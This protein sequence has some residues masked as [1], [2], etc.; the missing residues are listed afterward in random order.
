MPWNA[1]QAQCRSKGGDL[2]KIQSEE[3]QGCRRGRQSSNNRLSVMAVTR[4]DIEELIEEQLNS[5]EE[6]VTE[7]HNNQTTNFPLS[8]TWLLQAWGYNGGADKEDGEAETGGG[9]GPVDNTRVEA[10]RSGAASSKVEAAVLRA[11]GDGAAIP[12]A[13]GGGAAT[14]R[15]TN[16]ASES[17]IAEGGS[18]SRHRGH[19]A[20]MPRP[21]CA[22]PCSQLA[23]LPGTVSCLVPTPP[24]LE[25]QTSLRKR[26]M[27]L[28]FPLLIA[29]LPL[30][31]ATLHLGF[32]RSLRR[33]TG[34]CLCLSVLAPG[35]RSALWLPW[36]SRL[37]PSL[38]TPEGPT[39]PQ[40]RPWKRAK[41]DI[42]G[43]EGRTSRATILEGLD[44]EQTYKDPSKKRQLEPSWE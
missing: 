35:H 17:G 9:R 21:P 44:S 19:L 7:Q 43:L 13:R 4:G 36:S 6:L 10:N 27:S 42:C 30:P 2:V 5:C 23:A 34:A 20:G 1:S 33:S 31:S 15:T 32:Q 18:R 8:P 24:P 26:Q 22:G 38:V 12:R 37:G 28:A 11:R 39:H 25:S 41:I 3:E 14:F 16:R 29:P 40:A